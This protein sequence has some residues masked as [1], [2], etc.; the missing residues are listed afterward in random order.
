MNNSIILKVEEILLSQAYKKVRIH[1]RRSGRKTGI[2]A[3]SVN[4]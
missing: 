3:R 4:C 1:L 2:K